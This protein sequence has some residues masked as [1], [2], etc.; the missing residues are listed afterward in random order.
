MMPEGEAG[1]VRDEVKCAAAA[2]SRRGAAG[3]GDEAARGAD[4][5]GQVPDCRGPDRRSRSRDDG[6]AAT[7]CHAVILAGGCRAEDCPRGF[8]HAALRLLSLS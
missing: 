8:S 6:E 5:L 2:P 7:C 1:A 4:G 3:E